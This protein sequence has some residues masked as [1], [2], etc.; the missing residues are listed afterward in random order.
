L[1]GL[2]DGGG[3]VLDLHRM[4]STRSGQASSSSRVR[5]RKPFFIRSRSGVE[6]FEIMS[7]P[8]W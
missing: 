2:L 7:L 4:S 6:S 8:T 5:A 3:D 1:G